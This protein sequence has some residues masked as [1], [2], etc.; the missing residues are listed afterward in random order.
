M[1]FGLLA[2]GISITGILAARFTIVLAGGAIPGNKTIALSAAL[3]WIILGSVLAY[4]TVKPFGRIAGPGMQVFLVLTAV[5]A[6]IEFMFSTIGDH[7]P[8]EKF[9][10][11]AG[12]TIMG[13]SSSPIS[14]VAA[15][16]AAIAALS[17]AAVIRS[18]GIPGNT[19]RM[20]DEA[21]IFGFLISLVSI[22]FVVSY[23][24]GNPLLYGTDFIPI[25]FM[26]ALAAF[27]IGASLIA[28]AGPGAFP[29]KYLVGDSTS[30]RLFRVFVPLVAVTIL[31][32]NLIFVGLSSWFSI[33]DAVLLSSILVVFVFATALVVARVSRGMGRA[34][35]KVK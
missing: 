9:F 6:A 33:R 16:L 28:A 18:T 20:R 13:P 26:S 35:E 22:T 24:Y 1:V 17:L 14:P 15:V 32:E 34:L 12:M 21:S 3:I 31:A 29:V 2:A 5:A 8:L 27:F 10:I 4:Q 7:S 11:R 25:A 23:A 19:T 30:A